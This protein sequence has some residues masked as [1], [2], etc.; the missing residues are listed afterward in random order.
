M[1][2]KNA[3]K[4]IRLTNFLCSENFKRTSFKFKN[5]DMVFYMFSKTIFKDSFNNQEP[6][7]SYMLVSFYMFNVFFGF[8]VFFFFFFS[9]FSSSMRNN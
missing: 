4:I 5:T 3:G 8:G 7:K 9:F 1:K 6:N 2:S